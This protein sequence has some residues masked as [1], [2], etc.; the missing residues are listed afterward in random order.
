MKKAGGNREIADKLKISLSKIKDIETKST[1]AEIMPELDFVFNGLG[2][3]KSVDPLTQ[4]NNQSGSFAEYNKNNDY[5]ETEEG[6][7][8]AGM[9]NL[10]QAQ[11]DNN[12]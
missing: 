11:P 1:E 4:A 8:L 2:I 3:S 5:S 6:K 10:S 12:K 7:A 9:L